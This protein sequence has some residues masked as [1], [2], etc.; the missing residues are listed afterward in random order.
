MTISREEF[1]RTFIGAFY[2]VV[3]ES[4]LAGA[5]SPVYSAPSPM[6]SEEGAYSLLPVNMDGSRGNQSPASPP[7][8][9]SSPPRVSGVMYPASPPLSPPWAPSSP[10]RS[11]TPPPP[12]LG[13]GPPQIQREWQVGDG[14]LRFWLAPPDVDDVDA[15]PSFIRVV[16]YPVSE[17]VSAPVAHTCNWQLDLPAFTDLDTMK[18]ALQTV[19]N[20]PKMSFNML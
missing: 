12:G 18:L 14:P 17:R 5:S 10:P 16:I 3:E 20:D 15:R 19:S 6:Y 2:E 13:P 1:D 4:G 9:P 11:P 7:W 8:A